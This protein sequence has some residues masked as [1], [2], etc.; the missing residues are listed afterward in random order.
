MINARQI[1]GIMEDTDTKPE[2]P[3][4][5]DNEADEPSEP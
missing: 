5:N 2:I 4:D 3:S 1:T